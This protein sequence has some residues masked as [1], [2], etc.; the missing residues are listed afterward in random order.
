MHP[1]GCVAPAGWCSL[2]RG[3]AGPV[4]VPLRDV[5]FSALSVLVQ[6]ELADVAQVEGPDRPSLFCLRLLCLAPSPGR[7]RP[8]SLPFNV[9]KTPRAVED[10]NDAPRPRT[11]PLRLA[12]CLLR[13]RT[14]VGPRIKQASTPLH[15]A[16]FISTCLSLAKNL[17]P[18]RLNG[19]QPGRC[20]KKPGNREKE[21]KKKKSER[22]EGLPRA[23]PWLRC[24]PR[25]A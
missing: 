9:T 18:E 13:T 23:V 19:E 11:P 24:A 15:P 17:P 10:V 8:S 6:L 1:S 21:K 7:W 22:Q 2:G 16:T 12:C 25:H 5:P 3:W 20:S 4:L 14:P